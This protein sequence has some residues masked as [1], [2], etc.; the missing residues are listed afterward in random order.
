MGLRKI[1]SNRRRYHLELEAWREASRLD[2]VTQRPRPLWWSAYL[3]DV[4]E[5]LG[6]TEE[7]IIRL[8]EEIANA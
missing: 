5:A 2:D 1:C 8:D 6:A 3:F 7:D 4:G